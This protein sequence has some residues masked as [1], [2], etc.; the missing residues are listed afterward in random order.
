MIYDGIENSE[1]IEKELLLQ[2]SEKTP[3]Y[4]SEVT[5]SLR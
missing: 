1:N 3:S 4:T 5:R 2:A